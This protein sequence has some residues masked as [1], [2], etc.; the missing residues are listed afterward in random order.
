MRELLKQ[1]GPLTGTS[2]NRTG[3]PPAQT[4]E[5]VIQQLESD[6]DLILDGGPTPGGE[7]S[8]VLQVE[9]DFRIVRPGAISQQAIQTVLG[10][11]ILSD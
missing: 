11:V 8:T 3:H 6:I 7:P 1:T 5:E 10:N 9:P 2:A 4:V